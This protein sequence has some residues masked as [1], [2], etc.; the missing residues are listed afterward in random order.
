MTIS[1]GGAVGTDV[2]ELHSYATWTSVV[3][4]VQAGIDFFEQ[5]ARE[6]QDAVTRGWR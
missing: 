6:I 5:G 4:I 2:G 1:G 3:D